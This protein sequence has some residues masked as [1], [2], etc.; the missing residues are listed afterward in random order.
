MH[1]WLDWKRGGGNP[2]SSSWK[3]TKIMKQKILTAACLLGCLSFAAPADD[4]G[5]VEPKAYGRIFDDIMN[6]LPEELK[7]EVD[8]ASRVRVSAEKDTEHPAPSSGTNETH[9]HEQR[10]NRMKSDALDE[11]PEDVRKRVEKAMETL[12][13]KRETKM[14][15]FKEKRGAG[16]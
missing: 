8:S 6:S 2:S 5:A 4:E 13:T 3:G 10:M 9:G 16:E 1:R 11:L 14:M 12:E 7:A 15:Q